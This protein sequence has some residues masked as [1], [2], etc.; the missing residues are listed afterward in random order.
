MSCNTAVTAPLRGVLGNYAK[1]LK[2]NRKKRRL[3]CAQLLM[4]K[5]CRPA[6]TLWPAWCLLLKLHS[7]TPRADGVQHHPKH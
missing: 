2:H 1:K 4:F 3:G 7:L 5:R 6:E